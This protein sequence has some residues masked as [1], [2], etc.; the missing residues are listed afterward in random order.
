MPS[1]VP[2]TSPLYGLHRSGMDLGNSRS[3]STCMTG[4]AVFVKPSANLRYYV[5]PVFGPH[6][7]TFARLKYRLAPGGSHNRRALDS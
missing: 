7:T 3:L 4:R 1:L 2:S 6:P 5:I